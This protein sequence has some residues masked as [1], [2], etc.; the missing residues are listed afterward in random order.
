M[1]L[2]IS[3]LKQVPYLNQIVIGLDRADETNT[4]TL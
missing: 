3:E 2:I 1:P 4:A